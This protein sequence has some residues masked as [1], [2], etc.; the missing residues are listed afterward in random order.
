MWV[1]RVTADEDKSGMRMRCQIA[2]G[3]PVRWVSH[4]EFMRMLIRALRRADVPVQY[5]EGYNP[6]PKMSFATARPVGLSSCAEFTD[7]YME[8]EICPEIFS[9]ALNEVFPDGFS[10]HRCKP[11]LMSGPSLMSSVNAARYEF[12][13]PNI[14]GSFDDW[15][16][17]V[18]QFLARDSIVITRRRHRKPDRQLDIRPHIYEVEVEKKDMDTS[19]VVDMGLGN[20][21]NV[22]PEEFISALKPLVLDVIGRSFSGMRVHRLNIYRREEGQKISVWQI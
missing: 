5:T 7:I 17:L 20:E 8:K 1:M 12:L 15:D 14:E 21:Q 11:A 9:L 18:E 10:V 16:R 2:V 6:R 19:F 3:P 4:L 13:I 22:R